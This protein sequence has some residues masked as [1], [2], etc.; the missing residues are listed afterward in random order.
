MAEGINMLK[1]Y[2]SDCEALIAEMD[3][4]EEELKKKI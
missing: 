3:R 4:K 2:D 1:K